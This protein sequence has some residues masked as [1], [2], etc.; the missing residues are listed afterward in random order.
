LNKDISDLFQF[1]GLNEVEKS[2]KIKH[3]CKLH[4]LCPYKVKLNEVMNHKNA[5]HLEIDT[6][7]WEFA[8]EQFVQMASSDSSHLTD[9]SYKD[10]LRGHLLANIKNFVHWFDLY[11]KKV[12][13]ASTNDHEM[14][15]K[16]QSNRKRIQSAFSGKA[17]ESHLNLFMERFASEISVGVFAA[18]LTKNLS[19]LEIEP[20]V[21]FQHR[22]LM[23]S[24]S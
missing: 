15:T 7:Y 9:P 4:E 14:A 12:L 20:V 8:V 3:W 19:S 22:S 6:A 16:L 21:S 11:T 13:N 1:H 17:K 5:V 24:V 18:S 2:Q 23:K 10:Q